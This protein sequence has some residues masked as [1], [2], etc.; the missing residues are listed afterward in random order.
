MSTAQELSNISSD[1]IWEIV[2]ESPFDK[3]LI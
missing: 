1:L 3:F 2:R